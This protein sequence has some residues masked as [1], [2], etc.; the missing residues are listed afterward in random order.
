MSSGAHPEITTRRAT[1]D[2][3]ALLAELGASTFTE[4]F[5]EANHPDD[6]AAYV[7][8]A[9]GEAI[10]RA[11]LVDA[12]VTVILAERGS[13]TVGYV[14][15]RERPAPSMVSADDALEIARLYSRRSAIGT[16]VGAVLMQ[17]AVREAMARGK[18]A[19][20]L[21]VW[22]RNARAIE[23]YRRHEFFQA[24]T[25]PFPLGTDLQTDLVLVRRLA[26]ES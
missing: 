26:R 25:Q 22:E 9:F 11:E 19:L 15:L 12:N 14:M 21:G 6:F 2:D 4:T 7:S 5:A 3:A 10:Q 17:H 23:F 24:G 1:P 16:G 8:A 20:W 13:E 18:D